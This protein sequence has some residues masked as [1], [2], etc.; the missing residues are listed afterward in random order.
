MYN[1]QRY[2]LECPWLKDMTLP[3]ST[4]KCARVRP[5]AMKSMFSSR[6][7]VV[8]WQSLCRYMQKNGKCGSMLRRQEAGVEGGGAGGQQVMGQEQGVGRLGRVRGEGG[9][10][11]RQQR[12]SRRCAPSPSRCAQENCLTF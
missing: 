10:G 3:K 9:G 6:H 2:V 4:E 1:P 7:T 8:L 5:T 11:S 12:C